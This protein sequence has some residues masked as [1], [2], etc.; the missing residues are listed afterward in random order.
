MS[1][2]KEL[3][4]DM[5][6]GLVAKHQQA[7]NHEAFMLIARIEAISEYLNLYLKHQKNFKK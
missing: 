2:N 4:P 5:I 6:K 3:V 7:K 1:V